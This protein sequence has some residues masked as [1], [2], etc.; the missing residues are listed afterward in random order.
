MEKLIKIEKASKQAAVKQLHKILDK[1]IKL[2]SGYDENSENRQEMLDV[3]LDLK[4]FLVFAERRF[5]SDFM[6]M[7]A[8]GS[9]A[10]SIKD[11]KQFGDF[12]NEI[13]SQ[14]VFLDAS[15]VGHA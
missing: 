7:F 3:S 6:E 10:V 9:I 5:K 11:P 12:V 1:Q 13:V 14:I 15:S 8:I 2:I 4:A